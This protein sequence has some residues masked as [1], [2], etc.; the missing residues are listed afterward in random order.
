MGG[1]PSAGT[2]LPTAQGPSSLAGSP[3]LPLSSIPA[4]SFPKRQEP[5]RELPFS[6]FP[7]KEQTCIIIL[8]GKPASLSLGGLANLQEEGRLASPP[9]NPGTTDRT[10]AVPSKPS[11]GSPRWHLTLPESTWVGGGGGVRSVCFFCLPGRGQGRCGGHLSL[12]SLRS[13]S[14]IARRPLLVCEEAQFSLVPFPL[15]CPLPRITPFR[16]DSSLQT[17]VPTVAR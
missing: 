17:A 11:P 5:R 3:S 13:H 8:G 7:C 16:C 4:A 10:K 14:R 6:P 15:G 1:G 12:V 2:L 9:A